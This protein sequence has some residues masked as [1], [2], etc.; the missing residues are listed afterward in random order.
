MKELILIEIGFV[1]NAL[2][3]LTLALILANMS[4]WQYDFLKDQD[5]N[6]YTTLDDPEENYGHSLSLNS[7]REVKNKVNLF[8]SQALDTTELSI[9]GTVLTKNETK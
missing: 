1:L 2:A 7:P 6:T 9:V 3:Y 5:T 8:S 4:T